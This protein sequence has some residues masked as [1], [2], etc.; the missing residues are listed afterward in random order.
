MSFN[1]QDH[2]EIVSLTENVF[3]KHEHKIYDEVN[4]VLKKLVRNKIYIFFLMK[5]TNFKA[6]K[7][8]MSQHYYH[9]LCSVSQDSGTS[10]PLEI[11]EDIVDHP[12]PPTQVFLSTSQH[13]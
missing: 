10:D 8:V 3:L 13:F 5:I 1:N 2:Q 7:V 11:P 12:A 4:K 9:T 6:K